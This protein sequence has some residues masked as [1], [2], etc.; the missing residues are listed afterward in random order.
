MVASNGACCTAGD[1]AW[2]HLDEARNWRYE[3]ELEMS[4]KTQIKTHGA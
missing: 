1:A 4:L 3:E 2:S